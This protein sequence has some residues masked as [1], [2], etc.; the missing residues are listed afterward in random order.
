MSWVCTYI[1]ISLRCNNGW[2]TDGVMHE[3]VILTVKQRKF[4]CHA[5]VQSRI[6]L[7]ILRGTSYA[8]FWMHTAFSTQQ[9]VAHLRPTNHSQN[10]CTTTNNNQHD[11][12]KAQEPVRSCKCSTLLVVRFFSTKNDDSLYSLLLWVF[13]GSSERGRHK[14]VVGYDSFPPQI[15]TM[16][17][18]ASSWPSSLL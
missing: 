15:E 1:P 13:S 16:F 14:R 18:A 11:D 3:N 5:G 6:S 4:H 7:E 8:H 9:V 12:K 17:T 10:S 2:R